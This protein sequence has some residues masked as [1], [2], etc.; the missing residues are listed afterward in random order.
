MRTFSQM[1][2]VQE[3]LSTVSTIQKNRNHR[4][5]Q[6]VDMRPSTSEN[7]QPGT[8]ADR[9][10]SAGPPH[11]DH[12]PHCLF[13]L[14]AVGTAAASWGATEKPTSTKQG[15]EGLQALAVLPSSC[16]SCLSLARS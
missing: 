6:R 7:S 12:L 1:S 16:R 14:R 11:T 15:S 10:N 5:N 9:R 13:S 4:Y 8:A 2:T 3:Q